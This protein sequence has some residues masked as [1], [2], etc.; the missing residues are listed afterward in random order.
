MRWLFWLLLLVSLMFFA[1]MQ[2]GGAWM[3]D[4]KNPQSQPPLNAEKIKL[5]EPP[6]ESQSAAPLSS[7][8][9]CM[10]W[11]EFSGNDLARATTAL[12]AL[13]LGDKLMQKQAEHVSGY[14]VYIPPLKSRADVDKKIAQ[15]KTFGV[16]EYFV[17]Q[18][19][20]KWQNAISLGLFKTEDAA[21]NFLD[22]IKAKGVK[23]AMVGERVGKQMVTIFVLKNPDTALT[24]KMV[25]LQ[26]D[27]P[28]S[29]VRA[30][31]C[32]N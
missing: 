4:G 2:W 12:S 20:G 23:S 3:G 19:A 25:A 11:G 26:K 15:L 18:E 13:K 17:V 6:G 32:A 8:A 27:F 9:A 7:A 21:Q 1:F 16:E 29:E 14:W 5:L 28:G 22:S 10:E 31:A 30:A 24:A